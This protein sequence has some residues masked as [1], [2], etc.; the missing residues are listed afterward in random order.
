MP[1]GGHRARR[2][3][4]NATLTAAVSA[5]NGPRLLDTLLLGECNARG[6]DV[7]VDESD[8]VVAAVGDDDGGCGRTSAGDMASCDID[9]N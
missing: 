7:G 3:A 1:F 6:M 9:G 4:T 2:I 5:L 8:V